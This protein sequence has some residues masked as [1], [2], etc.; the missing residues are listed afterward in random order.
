MVVAGIS[1]QLLLEYS[2]NRPVAPIGLDPTRKRPPF[3][4]DQAGIDLPVALDMSKFIKV[5]AGP[6][7]PRGR[8]PVDC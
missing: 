4:D 6:G 3:D 2:P 7:G 5:D 8:V 1:A